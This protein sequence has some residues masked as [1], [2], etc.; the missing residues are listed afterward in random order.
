MKHIRTLLFI[1]LSFCFVATLGAQDI[2][3]SMFNM[4]PLTVNPAQTGA[5]RGTIRIGAIH[6]SQWQSS[7]SDFATTSLY[8]D[9]PILAIGKKKRDW[10]G[11]GVTV[12]QDVAGKE[13]M[14]FGGL[15][16]SFLMPSA[17]IHKVLGK[18]GD[19]VLTFGVQGG[20]VSRQISTDGLVF[21]DELS[22]AVGGG[23][24]GMATSADLNNLVGKQVDNGENVAQSTP[25]T[26]ISAGITLTSRLSEKSDFRI[27]AALGHIVKIGGY[28]LV[29]GGGAGGPGT[30][31]GSIPSI[32]KRPSTVKFHANYNQQITDKWS[33]HPM[34]FFQTTKGLSEMIL[35]GHAG[36][37]LNKD[38]RLRGGLGYRLGDAMMVI[39]GVEYKDWRVGL[40]YDL[41]VG[42]VADVGLQNAFEVAASYIIKL[43]KDPI[44]EPVIICPEF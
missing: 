39:G 31:G 13:Q 7:T 38:F 10:I 23:G 19:N 2:H 3:F 29:S 21:Q 42:Q 36:Y 25:F 40:N 17:S 18:D 37:Q 12:L 20:A 11:V 5:F 9:A 26:D 28:N 33:I 44:I 35:Q 6:R 27:G 34:A 43:Y 24:L 41:T 14:D 32:L 16:T 30:G 1:T 4:S 22:E 8:A 15:T